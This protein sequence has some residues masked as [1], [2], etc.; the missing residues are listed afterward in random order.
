MLAAVYTGRVTV[1]TAGVVISVILAVATF[2]YVLLTYSMASA[3]QANLEQTKEL[4]KLR[5]KPDIIRIIE[6]EIDPLLADLWTHRN[7]FNAD[8]LNAYDSWGHPE[9]RPIF[10]RHPELES[11]FERP[12]V[13]ASLSQEVDVDA[14]DVYAY[15]H[16]LKQSQEMHSRAV[17]DLSMVLLEHI[18]DLG[19]NSDEVQAYAKSALAIERSGYIETGGGHRMT[20]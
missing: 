2:S 8:G 6:N 5:R 3:M 9:K 10:D 18:D 11:R 4:F 7:T 13:A 12:D 17:T 1:D 14:G 19:I 20:M 15:Y 16:S